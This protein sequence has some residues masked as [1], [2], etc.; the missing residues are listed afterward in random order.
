MAGLKVKNSDLTVIVLAGGFGTR[1]QAL[2]ST[3]PKPMIEVA[4]KPFLYWFLSSY[5]KQG[6]R[7]FILSTGYLAEQIEQA[8]WQEQFSGCTFE[9]FREDT[10]LGTGGAVAAI[11]RA[12]TDLDQAWVVNGDTFLTAAL[13]LWDSAQEVDSLFTF[14]DRKEVFD[15]TP[16]I[17]I[18]GKY[19]VGEG[20]EGAYFD[21]GAVFLRRAGLPGGQGLSLV[22][23]FSLHRLLAEAMGRHRVGWAMLGGTCYDIGTPERYHRFE[24]FL[25]LSNAGS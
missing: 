11:F 19:V 15:A 23:P 18:D 21:A 10:P 4:G 25:S 9:F 17:H 14:L 6:F 5:R 20:P 7:K 3:R 2:D 16:N 12:K 1:L 8:P 24:S 13:P 22:A